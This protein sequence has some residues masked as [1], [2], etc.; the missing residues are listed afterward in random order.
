VATEYSPPNTGADLLNKIANRWVQREYRFT[1]DLPEGWRP[2]LAPSEVALLFANGPAHGVWSDNVLVIA[3]PHGRSDLKEQAEQLPGLFKQEDPNCEILSCKVVAQGKLKALETVV[4]T[5]RGP[6][7]MTVIERRFRGSRYDYEIKYTL[8]SKRFDTLMPSLRKS[9][10]T[11]H[12]MPG[13]TPG[14]AAKAA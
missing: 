7:S 1:L 12:E 5:R 3:H 9:F 13:T 11:F 8:E 14:G 6:F 2:V 10:D 4:R